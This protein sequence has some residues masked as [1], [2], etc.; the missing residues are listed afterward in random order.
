MLALRAERTDT[1]R[2]VIAELTDENLAGMTEPVIE[3]DYPEPESFA[4]LR[5]L[6]VILS[7]EWEHR[8]TPKGD[9]DGLESRS[10]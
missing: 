2:Q 9:F 5:C 4:L 3:P 6:R 7:E 10:S 1:V 8:G